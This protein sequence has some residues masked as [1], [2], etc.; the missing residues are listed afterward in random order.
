MSTLAGYTISGPLHEGADASLSSGLSGLS[1]LAGPL[2]LS[3]HE[4]ASG[5]PVLIKVASAESPQPH[6]LARLRHE[7]LILRSLSIPGVVRALGIERYG[8]GLALILEGVRG[9]PLSTY[10]RARRPDL[11]TAVR[12]AVRLSDILHALHGCGVSHRDLKPHLIRTV[13]RRPRF[14]SAPRTRRPGSD[15]SR[16][17]PCGSIAPGPTERCRR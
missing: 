8:S 12:I 1:G 15:G 3:G 9:Q 11:I 2:L 4:R 10:L 17:W 7:Y 14:R 6:E 16:A 13:K 5:A